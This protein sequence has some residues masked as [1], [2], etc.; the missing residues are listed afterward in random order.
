MKL[1]Y[2]LVLFLSLPSLSAS[3]SPINIFNVLED[4]EEFEIPQRGIEPLMISIGYNCWGAYQIQKHGWRT[5]SFPFDWNLTPVKGINQILQDNFRYFLDET[6]LIT[7]HIYHQFVYNVYYNI[8]FAHDFPVCAGEIICDGWQQHLPE[9]KN[10][11]ERR[12]QKFNN[13]SDY[14]G[15]IF[16]IRLI[17]A[18]NQLNIDEI[19]ILKNELI[20]KFPSVDFDLVL[21]FCGVDKKYEW[22]NYGIKDFYIPLV[23]EW[24]Q[25]WDDKEFEQKFCDI[26]ESLGLQKKVS[27]FHGIN[28]HA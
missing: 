14:K 13:L 24:E 21:I 5:A 7:R 15:K 11:Y 2:L 6:H 4:V 22:L 12:I 8:F 18:F 25:F 19:I 27:D 1:P 26:F 17:F 20:K 3:F 16:F 23:G 28:Y 10:K 9:V